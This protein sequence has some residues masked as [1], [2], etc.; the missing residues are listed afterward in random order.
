MAVRNAKGQFEKG[1]SGNGNGR[2]ARKKPS[3]R[4]PALNRKAILEIAEKEME[5][6]VNGERQ[7]M[8][9]Y[10]AALW[11]MGIAAVKGDRVAARQ[12]VQLVSDT[13]KEDL[14]MS[15]RTRLLMDEMNDV[16]DENERLK[17]KVEQRTGVVIDRNYDWSWTGVSE[18]ARL[19]DGRR[20]MEGD[21]EQAKA[22]PDDLTED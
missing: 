18:D 5:V 11:Q 10:Q 1:F 4:L 17:D 15:L 6:T 13:A 21:D 16:R 12:F 3:H 19:D 20:T 7:T 14:T 2:G 8:S 22:N 9:I